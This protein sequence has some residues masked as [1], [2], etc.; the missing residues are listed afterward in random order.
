MK[1]LKTTESNI[2][3]MPLGVSSV[4][5][6]ILLVLVFLIVLERSL[7]V[8]KLFWG[9][10]RLEGDLREHLDELASKE[11]I[12]L[13]DIRVKRNSHKPDAVV[14]STFRTYHV[15]INDAL[16]NEFSREEIEA[17]FMHEIGHIKTRDKNL[18]HNRA[19]F[20]TVTLSLSGI[21]FM[22][23]RESL[24]AFVV[25]SWALVYLFLRRRTAPD[26][27]F[28][29]DDYAVRKVGKD[30]LVR[31]LTKYTRFYPGYSQRPSIPERINRIEQKHEAE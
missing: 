16:L 5:I 28:Q 31:A 27:E 18:V 19:L 21:S 17:V 30:G 12:N 8:L 11:G 20:V 4:L 25:V 15:V 10:E 26:L 24:T 6:K 23:L 9:S 29:A 1:Q 7:S 3:R 2:L 13:E 22:T 14:I